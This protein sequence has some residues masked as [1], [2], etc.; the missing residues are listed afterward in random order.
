MKRIALI[1]LF[2]LAANLIYAQSVIQVF[3]NEKIEIKTYD[4]VGKERS[5]Q[6][7]LQMEKENFAVLKQGVQTAIDATEG[8]SIST[9]DVTSLENHNEKN[10]FNQWSESDA[11]MQIYVNFHDYGEHL[12]VKINGIASEAVIDLVGKEK[13]QKLLSLFGGE[14]ENNEWVISQPVSISDFNNVD[15]GSFL[16]DVDEEKEE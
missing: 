11:E 8:Q 1:G 4:Y 13:M 2:C 5:L 12:F 6:I 9:F 7:H 14:M 3:F 15:W 16:K 10:G